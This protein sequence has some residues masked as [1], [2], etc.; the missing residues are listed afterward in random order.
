MVWRGHIGRI[1]TL[2]E[3]GCLFLA[4]LA[5]GQQSLWDGASSDRRPLAALSQKLPGRFQPN[6]HRRLLLWQGRKL[7]FFCSSLKKDGRRY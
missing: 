7:T 3:D 2:K 5:K 6:F 1:R 4:L